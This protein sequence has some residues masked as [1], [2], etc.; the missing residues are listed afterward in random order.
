[1]VY[2]YRIAYFVEVF[3]YQ[4]AQQVN[5]YRDWNEIDYIYP[6][7]YGTFEEYCFVFHIEYKGE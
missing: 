4:L 3:L 7:C 1:M 2:N 6:A 5:L